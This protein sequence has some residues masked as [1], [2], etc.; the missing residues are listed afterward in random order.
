MGFPLSRY[1]CAITLHPI[2]KKR[3]QQPSAGLLD[4]TG[5]TC[6]PCAKSG[7]RIAIFDR[8]RRC[9]LPYNTVLPVAFVLLSSSHAIFQKPSSFCNHER[10]RVSESRVV[11][12][13]SSHSC[14]SCVCIWRCGDRAC[15]KV[16]GYVA[17][18]LES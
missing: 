4:V 8:C 2:S 14:I 17:F 16:G 13:V 9:N 7:V 15:L 6:D 11:M 10:C 3:N 18:D 5:A 1:P 12:H